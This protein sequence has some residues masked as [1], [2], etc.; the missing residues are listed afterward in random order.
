MAEG[1]F[2]AQT[3]TL[4]RQ[5]T[6]RFGPLPTPTT[7]RIRT[8]SRADIDRSLLRVLDATTLAEALAPNSPPATLRNRQGRAPKSRP[9]KEGKRS[10]AE[11]GALAPLSTAPAPPDAAWS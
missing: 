3:T 4:L 10:R 6:Q 7:D 8:A 1:Q 9:G 5:L 2:E 11:A